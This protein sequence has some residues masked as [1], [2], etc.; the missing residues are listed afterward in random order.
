MGRCFSHAVFKCQTYSLKCTNNFCNAHSYD[1]RECQRYKGFANNFFSFRYTCLLIKQQTNVPLLFKSFA[2][3][4]YDCENFSIEVR[5]LFLA[6]V[7]ND[8]C[9][10]LW[11]LLF[12]YSMWMSYCSTNSF[13]V[14]MTSNS[15]WTPKEIDEIE[16][17]ERFCSPYL[18]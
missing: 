1:I 6:A 12:W 10:T 3:H 16:M 14:T 13:L 8:W 11:W 2:Q 7:V 18:H 9:N 4:L 15:A 17:L 5:I